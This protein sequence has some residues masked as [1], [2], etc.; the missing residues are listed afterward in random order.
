MA[1]LYDRAERPE[2]GSS[3]T[4]ADVDQTTK[5]ARE[6]GAEVLVE[7]FDAPGGGRVA[8]VRDP[9]GA[10]VSLSRPGELFAAEVMLKLNP[11]DPDGVDV[12]R[13]LGRQP[14]RELALHIGA[15]LQEVMGMEL[16]MPGGGQLPPPNSKQAA[17]VARS[18]IVAPRPAAFDSKVLTDE[19][20]AAVRRYAEV[21]V[22]RMMLQD[23]LPWDLGMVDVMGEE[24]V[25]R[26]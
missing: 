7:P 1:G 12:L 21:G 4:V 3:I 22:E 10:A 8:T 9:A 16:G 18:D 25:G 6:L 5:R 19:A 2:W 17:D 26:V 13:G 14:N 11:N 15:I 20:R 23:F 24:L